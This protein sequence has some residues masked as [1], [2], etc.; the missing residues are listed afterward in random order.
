MYDN[1]C[2]NNKNIVHDFVTPASD[3]TPLVDSETAVAGTSNEFSRG[4][5][6]HPLKV[7]TVLPSKDTSIG[8]IGYASTYVRSTQQ[9]PIQTVDTI[10]VSDSADGSYDTVELY[11]LNDHSHPI[12]VQTNA[13]IVLVVNDV[14]NNCTSTYYLRHDHIHPQQLAPDGNLTAT[15]FNKSGG[16]SNDILLADGTT[17]N[18]FQQVN[19]M[20]LLNSL[21]ILKFIPSDYLSKL[22]HVQHSYCVSTYLT[23][24]DVLRKFQI[25]LQKISTPAEPRERVNL[26]GLADPQADWTRTMYC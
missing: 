2:Y 6:K 26:N 18:Q 13:S 9:N 19:Y 22:A 25:K 7:S 24:S 3:A 11:A 12:N 1:S 16:T 4:V 15:K 14:V 10:Q 17:K 23:V 5:H 8:T 20:K 21:N